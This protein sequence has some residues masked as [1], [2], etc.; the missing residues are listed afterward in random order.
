VS[1]LLHDFENCINRVVEF[2]RREIIRPVAELAHYHSSMLDLQLNI[3]QDQ[4]CQQIV[5]SVTG[6][7]PYFNWEDQTI[8]L[9]SQAWIQ[10]QLRNLGY[11]IACHNLDHW[12]QH[13]QALADI[14]LNN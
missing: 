11:E 10:W 6:Q 3:S 12:P 5:A 7:Q 13:S 2:S 8:P 4:L 14:M 9:A 1:E